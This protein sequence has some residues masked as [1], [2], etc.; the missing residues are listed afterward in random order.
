MR[1]TWR[2]RDAL[3]ELLV[4]RAREASREES[5]DALGR[6]AAAASLRKIAREQGLGRGAGLRWMYEICDQ[7]LSSRFPP[8][9]GLRWIEERLEEAVLRGQV[10]VIPVAIPTGAGIPV[11]TPIEFEEP[12]RE[13]PVKEEVEATWVE[14]ELLNTAGEPIP[15][16]AFVLTLP[17]GQ[18]RK[19]RL[20]A[21]GFARVDNIPGGTC[22]VTFPAFDGREWKPKS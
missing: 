22:Q 20:D 19:G 3:R 14:I 17:D 15:R 5:G 7:S 6:E 21:Q 1:K 12:P 8:T 18:V 11:T 9:A 13:E 10:L 4:V 2:F 16:E